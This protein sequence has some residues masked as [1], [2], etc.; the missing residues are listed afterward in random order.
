MERSIEELCKYHNIAS[1]SRTPLVLLESEYPGSLASVRTKE[2][3]LALQASFDTKF[4]R[5]ELYSSVPDHSLGVPVLYRSV[6]AYEIDLL[7]KGQ[8]ISR[9]SIATYP[10]DALKDGTPFAVRKAVS[11]KD[12]R[13]NSMFPL[14]LS[15]FALQQEQ[16]YELGL[17]LGGVLADVDDS[18]GIDDLSEDQMGRILDVLF[19]GQSKRV[20]DGSITFSEVR[21]RLSTLP[22][23][24]QMR[25]QSSSMVVDFSTL[26]SATYGIPGNLSAPPPTFTVEFV[27]P[28]EQILWN[29]G[30]VASGELE[31]LTEKIKPEW[32]SRIFVGNRENESLENIYW[33]VYVSHYNDN[34]N[35]PLSRFTRGQCGEINVATLKHGHEMLSQQL[36][37]RIGNYLPLEIRNR[38]SL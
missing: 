9:S 32:V 11:L 35:L 26:L 21:E 27:P 25:I 4:Y 18:Y 31:V 13:F 34:P 22:L 30:I 12:H 19:S 8:E 6:K 24:L 36:R 5:P 17:P 37:Q 10:F 16:K 3:Y 7:I 15:V 38:F 28:N 29:E 2:D 14:L 20:M 1:E 33:E 23:E